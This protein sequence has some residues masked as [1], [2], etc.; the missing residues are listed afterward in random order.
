MTEQLLQFIWLHQYFD[1]TN[2]QTRSGEPIDVIHPGTWNRDQGPDF[3]QA[4]VRIG[5]TIWAGA[6]EIHLRSGDWDLHQ[7]QTDPRYQQVV[8]HVVWEHDK[9]ASIPCSELELYGRI[10]RMMLAQYAKW[11]DA[12]QRLPCAGQL[13]Q[14][15]DVIWM[16]WQE[17]LLVERLQQRAMRMKDAAEA[18]QFHWQQLA[19]Q[20]LARAYGGRLNGAAFE[21]MARSLPVRLLFR[22][23][24]HPARLEALLFGQLGLLEEVHIESYPQLLAR[25]YEV[26]RHKY[27]LRPVFAKLSRLRMRP[28][29]FP[30]LRLAQLAALLM[31]G[32]LVVLAL[33]DD[34]DLH[35]WMQQVQ[36]PANDYWH[37]HYRFGHISRCLPKVA[38]KQL[39]DRILLNAV[40][41]LRLAYAQWA[42]R[43]ISTEKVWSWYQ[44]IAPE[45]LARIK[46][47]EEHNRIPRHAGDT[48]ARL[49]LLDQYCLPKRCLDCAVGAWLLKPIDTLS[50]RPA[51]DVS[52]A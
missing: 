34:T 30:E 8:L 43:S 40:F 11:M 28:H 24:H 31:Q 15:P 23:L 7:H 45:A 26:L 2:L 25:E 32:D 17:Q 52:S 46:P 3:L 49:Q 37:Y 47:F 13:Q 18:I 5:E 36:V 1:K 29:D 9:A 51:Q 44:A 41:P 4:R 48:Q 12:H 38:G 22:E 21:L 20:E 35:V 39:V 33:L 19:W 42:G 10:S 27:G 50:L 6:V 16:K 14:L